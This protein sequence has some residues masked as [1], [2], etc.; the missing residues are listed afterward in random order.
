MGD[1]SFTPEEWERLYEKRRRAYAAK[2]DPKWKHAIG[3]LHSLS[4]KGPHRTNRA[5]CSPIPVY[6][7]RSVK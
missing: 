6:S 5:G 1:Q 3:G 2:T 4:C 7:L